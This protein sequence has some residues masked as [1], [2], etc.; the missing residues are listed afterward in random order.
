MCL[1]RCGNPSRRFSRATLQSHVES[2]RI[3]LRHVRELSYPTV[4]EGWFG[5]FDVL[6]LLREP[7]LP[8]RRLDCHLD[9]IATF[10]GPHPIL[11]STN[12]ALHVVR[13]QANL[14]SFRNSGADTSRTGSYQSNLFFQS[15]LLDSVRPSP[16]IVR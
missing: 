10:K 11:P 2:F 13:P 3:W 6:L 1:T 4:N 16:G 9:S 14:L 15:L 12:E 8:G 5:G 7:P